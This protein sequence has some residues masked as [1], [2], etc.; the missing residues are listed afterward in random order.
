MYTFLNEILGYIIW[1]N[2]QFS[3]VWSDFYSDYNAV[4]YNIYNL[5]FFLYFFYVFHSYT[6]RS[7]FRKIIKLGSVLFLITAIVNA[8]L[9]NFIL[10][11]QFFTYIIGASVLICCVIFYFLELKSNTG[12][13]FIKRDLVSWIGVGM[14]LFYTGYIPIKIL[15]Y[16]NS[17]HGVVEA[18]EVRPIHLFLILIMY[19]SFII[20][21]LLMRSRRLKRS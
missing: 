17:I 3:F 9:Q 19:G 6:K 5:F 18:S 16:Y 7:K 10:E 11:P 4:I 1:H 14:L 8:F 20:G 12:S 21:F 15:R 13:W 2:D